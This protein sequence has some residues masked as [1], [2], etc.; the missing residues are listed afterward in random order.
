MAGS[1]GALADDDWQDFWSN[2]SPVWRRVL[3]GSDI[4]A[5]PP[6]GPIL[7]RRRLTTDYEWVGAF[8]PVRWLPAVT[9][10]LPWD[11]NGMD[12]GP[13]T[14]RSWRSLQL[15]G[16]AGV[17]LAQL[18]GTP[19]QRLILSNVDVGDLSGLREIVGLESLVLAHGDFGSLQHLDHFTALVLHA[20]ADIDIAAARILGL[21]VIRSDEPYLPPFG[22]GDV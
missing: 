15:A 1:E 16:P 10:A 14:G 19:I 9:R 8:E 17:D 4:V 22:P 3:C 5:P 2:L 13:L 12:L 6:A 18:S 7:R 20:E 21:R 11:E